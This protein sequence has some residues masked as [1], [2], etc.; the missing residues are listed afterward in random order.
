M[1]SVIELSPK[2]KSPKSGNFTVK[3]YQMLNKHNFFQKTEC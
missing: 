1:K 2:D 3:I